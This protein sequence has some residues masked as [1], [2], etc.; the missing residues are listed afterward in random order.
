M[1]AK[2]SRMRRVITVAKH[3]EEQLRLLAEDAVNQVYISTSAQAYGEV[4]RH[5]IRRGVQFID[6]ELDIDDLPEQMAHWYLDDED[7]VSDSSPP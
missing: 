3:R 2:K 7:R 4:M 1:M 5:L 6:H